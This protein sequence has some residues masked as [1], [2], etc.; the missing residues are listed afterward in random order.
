MPKSKR[1]LRWL[2]GANATLGTPNN[3]CVCVCV[4]MIRILTLNILLL[5]AGQAETIYCIVPAISLRYKLCKAEYYLSNSQ[6]SYALEHR[7]RS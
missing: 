3:F 1:A 5:L 7:H 2:A 4:R 6:D